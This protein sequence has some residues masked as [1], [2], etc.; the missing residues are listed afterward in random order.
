MKIVCFQPLQLTQQQQKSF[1][2]SLSLSLESAQPPSSA[3]AIASSQNTG[4]PAAAANV[5]P[6][7]Q[8]MQ[9]L[10]QPLDIKQ[11]VSSVNNPSSSVNKIPNPGPIQFAKA[12]QPQP[13][14]TGNNNKSNINLNHI[15]QQT[16]ALAANTANPQSTHQQQQ[17]LLNPNHMNAMNM[18]N[19]GNGMQSTHSLSTPSIIQQQLTNN[20]TNPNQVKHQTPY[21]MNSYVDPLELS[22]A[23]LEQV[24]MNNNLQKNNPQ[25][26]SAMFMDMHKKQMLLSQM[27]ASHIAQSAGPNGFGSDFNGANGAVNN[28][29]NMLAMPSMDPSAFLNPQMMNVPGRFPDTWN[30]LPGNNSMIQ[31]LSAQ[32]HANQQHQA[33]S[34]ASQQHHQQQQ[35]QQQHQQ[36]SAKPEKIMLTPKPIE[37]LLINPNDKAKNICGTSGPNF[38]QAYNKYEQNLKNASS[39]SQLAA[40]GSPQNP[41]ASISS[42]SKVPS[43]TF[44]EYRTKAKEQQQRQKQEQEK[45]KKQKEQELKRQQESLQ[46]HKN[47]DLS[48]GH[49]Y[50][51]RFQIERIDSNVNPVQSFSENHQLIQLQTLWKK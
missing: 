47:E 36:S 35:P 33:H 19:A 2:S 18:Q 14:P 11:P 39:W 40:A 44:Q 42:K 41:G 7:S 38:G 48:N 17:S 27:G 43:D 9:Q 5:A 10:Q 34:H 24:Q 29:M 20:N 16:P 22:L 12:D 30:N 46:K 28:L 15:T 45:M 25:D 26:V 50:E 3:P 23:S 6:T 13:S 51:K 31:Q 32:Q 1:I 37:E 21:A 4:A 49:R 8:L